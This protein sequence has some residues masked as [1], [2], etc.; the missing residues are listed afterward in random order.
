MNRLL[1]AAFLIILLPAGYYLLGGFDEK[2]HVLQTVVPQ[3]D[4]ASA[5]AMPTQFSADLTVFADQRITVIKTY[6]SGVLARGEFELNGVPYVFIT[7]YD[8]N[9]VYELFPSI[10]VMVP[11]PLMNTQ[12][13]QDASPFTA[14]PKVRW[15]P[16]GS[17]TL[18]GISC[19]KYEKSSNLGPKMIVWV[20]PG[21]RNPIQ[22]VV[23]N[24]L[25]HKKKTFTHV[26]VGLQNPGL[27]KLPT[28]YRVM[29][30]KS[31]KL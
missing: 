29:D 31:L 7:H 3:A 6:F 11:R 9:L 16:M 17:E 24:T 2:A 1:L 19:L 26:Q 25:N 12:L 23:E 27:F 30:A 28:D 22:F 10:K 21:T 14:L 13:A 15:E 18:E 20:D 5:F 8:E 4:D